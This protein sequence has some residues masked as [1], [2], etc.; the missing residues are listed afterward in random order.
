PPAARGRAAVSSLALLAGLAA[1][2]VSLRTGAAHAPPA[3]PFRER[4]L[5]FLNTYCV[6]CHNAKTKNGDLDLTRFPTASTLVED[7]RQ[8]EH[9]VTFLKKG[10]MPPVKAK[11]PAAGLRAEVIATLEKVLLAEAR[12]L[13]GDP[14][15]VPPRR[16]TNAEYDYT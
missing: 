13:A 14:G 15:V 1:V 6:R 8:W 12:K 16:L 9:V 7:F 2:G 5:P 10:E 11:Q 3:D 4:V